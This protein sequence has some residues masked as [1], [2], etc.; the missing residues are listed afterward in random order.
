MNATAL[1]SVHVNRGFEALSCRLD[2]PSHD[3]LVELFSLY[4]VTGGP[5][6]RIATYL[7][8]GGGL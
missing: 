2:S 5:V 1:E 7:G 8:P 6:R 3:A 4:N